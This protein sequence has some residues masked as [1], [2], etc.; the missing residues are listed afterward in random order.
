MLLSQDKI[1][2]KKQCRFHKYFVEPCPVCL[3][4]K[5]LADKR[6]QE[7]IEHQKWLA[8]KYHVEHYLDK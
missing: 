6:E 4:E 1:A 5:A 2:N 8:E 7:Y 3:R